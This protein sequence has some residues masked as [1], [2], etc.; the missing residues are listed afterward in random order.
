MYGIFQEYVRIS[1]FYGFQ[2]LVQGNTRWYVLVLAS[3]YLTRYK[4][5]QKTSKWYIPVRTNIENSYDSTYW[6]VLPVV[7]TSLYL[8]STRWYKV[9]QDG[10]RWYKVVQT[11]VY[12]GHCTWRYKAV[13]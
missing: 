12:G 8:H 5:V 1:N 7:C 13:R 9:V 4:A 6:Y 10:T 3:T 11:T 2:M